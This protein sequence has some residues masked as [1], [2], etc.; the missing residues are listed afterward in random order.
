MRRL[1]LALFLG[2]VA[3]S[4]DAGELYYSLTT[5]T[6]NNIYAVN[7]AGGVPHIVL[8]S[9]EYSGVKPTRV[10]RFN[11][12]A[13]NGQALIRSATV[14]SADIELLYRA[15]D[16]TIVT[17]LVTNLG[18]NTFKP[19]YKPHVAQDDSFFS[20]RSQDGQ[21]NFAL[22]RLNVS[23][24]QALSPD[25]VPPTDYSDPRLKLLY[26]GYLNPQSGYVKALDH[27]W[28]ADG[29]RVVY[30]D[31]WQQTNGTLVESFYVKRMSDGATTLLYQTPLVGSNL[32]GT[33][34]EWSPTSDQILQY[35]NDGSGIFVLYANSPGRKTWL[36]QSR[37]YISKNTIV[38]DQPSWGLW[39][40]NG[41]GYAFALTRNIVPLRGTATTEFYPSVT[42]GGWPSTNLTASQPTYVLPIGWTP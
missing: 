38:T 19:Y 4:A 33:G 20:L 22:W 17:R 21:G 18:A 2:L 41:Q 40:N 1:L 15:T 9:T 34:L 39:R 31:T 11:H 29:S 10:T 14:Q 13:S 36:I 42:A 24:D 5:T 16:G 35:I 25:Y 7:E 12:V 26:S 23:V 32:P 30:L 37:S 27:S 28:S 3:S 6:D 8:H